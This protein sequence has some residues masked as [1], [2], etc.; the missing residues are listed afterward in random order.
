MNETYELLFSLLRASLWGQE[1]S[2]PE[3]A[4]MEALKKELAD[5]GVYTLTADV[6]GKTGD[7]SSIREAV[8]R[9]NRWH[10][11]MTVQN[12]ALRALETAGIEAVVLKGAAAD[13]YYPKPEYRTMGD[14]D[15]LVRLEDFP[16]ACDCLKKAGGTVYNDKPRHLGLAFGDAHIELHQFFT[17]EGGK[18]LDELLYAAIPG[19][20]YVKLGGT[21]FP[22]LPKKENGIVLLEHLAQ[23]LKDSV[24]LRQVIDWMLYAGKELNDEY[25]NAVFAPA[26]RPLGLE[27]LALAAT[28]MCQMY[29]GLGKEITWCAAADENICR[30]IME[31]VMDRGNFGAKDEDSN[32]AVSVLNMAKNPIRFLG[33]LQTMGLKNWKAAEKYPVLKPFAWAYQLCRFIKK[34][35]S[36]KNAF[37]QLKADKQKADKQEALLAD[38]EL[39]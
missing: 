8:A 38:L 22:M 3:N 1:F 20:S 18:P 30:G 5:Q 10:S 29:L 34:G 11:L 16:A 32:K 21:S 2:L 17:E 28:K 13:V 7:R 24:G 12:H 35:L 31:Q 4:D 6:L 36:R 39:N 25:Y 27:K 33:Q 23:H 37:S 14:I 9:I 15:L 26:I 19:R